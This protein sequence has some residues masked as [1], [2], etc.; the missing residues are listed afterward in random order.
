MA[1]RYELRAI[2]EVE[3]RKKL[4][5]YARRRHRECYPRGTRYAPPLPR[6]VTD[7]IVES[8]IE[9]K[10]GPAPEEF[11]PSYSE[12][13][14]G[15]VEEREALALDGVRTLYARTR[16][17]GAGWEVLEKLLEVLLTP[18]AGPSRSTSRPR[19]GAGRKPD[20][21]SH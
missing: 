19:Q 4:L 15:P 2:F 8:L 9:S 16:G 18:E 14:T 17:A 13:V 10:E 21:R 7:A 5:T 6:D 3:D 20:R 1:D 12:S 11:G